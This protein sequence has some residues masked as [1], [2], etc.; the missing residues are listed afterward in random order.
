MR[1]ILLPLAAA[2]ALTAV[3]IITAHAHASLEKREASPGSYKAVVRIPHGC[4]GQATHTVRLQIPEGYIGVKPMPKPGWI[5]AT[6]KGDY[7]R[8]YSLHGDEIM[9][10]VTE[11]TWSGGDLPDDFYDEFTVS[12]TLAGV[13]QGQTLFF[14][15]TQLCAAGKIAWTEE[16][17][18]GQDPHSLEYPAPMLK[19]A[20][21]GGDHE[22]HG[23]QSSTP[24]TV[25]DLEITGQ[26]ARAML[27]GQPAGGGYM[28][29][30]N[31]GS[32]SDRLVSITSAA[33]GKAE[34]HSM[35]VVDGV[36]VMR[37][38]TGGLDIPAGATV[39]LKPGGLHL[40]FMEVAQRFEEGASVSL[41][42][43]FEKAGKV[44]L[45]LPV[46]AAGGGDHSNH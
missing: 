13:E 16:P 19:I 8:K 43:E 3:S 7:A 45:T 39:E 11:V 28:T 30:A 15:T 1:R 40:M 41:T 18:E 26:W 42:L 21:K 34:I 23:A 25:G 14:K 36:M 31:K 20:A 46:R 24:I 9:S 29:I 33:A 32:E 12:G 38:V 10:G 35:E 37:P 4:D 27:P 44:E 2:C 6:V 22:G 5:I 17:A